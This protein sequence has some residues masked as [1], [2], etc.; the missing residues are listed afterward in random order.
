[1]TAVVGRAQLAAIGCDIVALDGAP[2]DRRGAALLRR[3]SGQAEPQLSLGDL[4][5][6]PGWLRLP[7]LAQRRLARH[8]ALASLSA[9]L[10]RSIDGRWLGE[11]ATVGGE[12]AVEWA[13]NVDPAMAQARALPPVEA[14]ALEARGF[15]L[16]RETLPTPLRELLNWAEAERAE[17][18][19]DRAG[20]CL[21]AALLAPQ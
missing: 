7:R 11:L 3:L 17:H 10:L 12:D 1:V 19:A 5:L 13:M 18:P 4:A 20:L 9:A 16:L 14:D 8:A 2:A 15:A 6:V 21:A